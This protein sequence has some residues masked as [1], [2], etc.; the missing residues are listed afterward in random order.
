MGPVTELI[1]SPNNRVLAGAANNTVILWN[2][3][4]RGYR[5]ALTIPIGQVAPIAFSPDGQ[6]LY[7][8][9]IGG[10]VLEWDVTGQASFGQRLAVSGQSPNPGTVAPP[11]P[12]LA[13]SPDGRTFAVRL[14]ASTVGLFSVRTL[15]RLVSFS[16]QPGVADITALAWSPTGPLLAVGGHS[17][18]VQ[19][20]RIDATPRLVRAL[21]GLHPIVGEPEAIQDIEFSPNGRLIAASEVFALSQLAGDSSTSDSR[22]RRAALLALWQTDTGRL[23][24][25]LYPLDLGRGLAPF[26]PLAFSP[27]SRLVAV[28]APDGSNFIIDT[29]TGEKRPL[30]Q[31]TGH[32]YTRSLAFSPNGTLA[33]GT[34]N[35]T[36]ELWNPIGREST[37]GPLLVT[38]GPVSSVA[39]D[40]TGQRFVTTASLD[41]SVK[42]FATSTL[43]QEGPTLETGPGAASTATFAPRSNSLLVANDDGNAFTWPVSTTALEQRACAI[44]GRNLTQQ[45]WN[46]FV[47]G[48]SYRRTCP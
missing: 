9:S 47:P 37:A 14:G 26:D 34:L 5:T 1:Y 38:A 23:S 19:L 30:L 42:L 22:N 6:T 27:N 13:V 29:S 31:P 17:D 12:P 2:P 16:V 40:S 45:E 41:G 39:F 15:Q 10:L 46:Q 35:G 18:L 4:S 32:Q 28:G 21:S 3:H 33:T 43:Q 8:S 20:W 36:V 44:A 24:S 48:Q 7:T 11:G 25:G